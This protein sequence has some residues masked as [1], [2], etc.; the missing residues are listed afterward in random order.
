MHPSPRIPVD[1]HSTAT[2]AA[3]CLKAVFAALYRYCGCGTFTTAPNIEPTETMLPGDVCFIK[4]TAVANRYVP[5]T[6]AAHDLR[7]LSIGY[8]I[9]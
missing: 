1:A 6:F 7:I 4:A 9:A 8:L 2:D 5:S 3:R